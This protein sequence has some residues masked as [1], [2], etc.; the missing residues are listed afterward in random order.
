AAA[1][2]HAVVVL[3]ATGQAG[4][5]VRLT[6]ALKRR[7]EIVGIVDWRLAE[8]ER[9]GVVFRFNTY[10]DAAAVLAENPDLVVV[11]TGGLPNTAFL[12]AGED[13]VTTS[14][15]VLSGAVRP[16]ASVLLYDDNGG[17]AG[18]TAAEFVLG[19]GGALQIVTPE[20]ILAPDVGG[21]NYP[22]Y[23]KSLAQ[24]GVVTTL[25]LRLTAVRR[26][27]NA[28]QAVFFDEYG[29]TEVIKTA[30]QIVVEHG[31]MPLDDLY[32]ALKPDSANLGEVDYGALLA[33]RPQDLVRNPRGRF[34][35]FRIGD[36]VAS[37][38]IHAAIFDAIRLLKDI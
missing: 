12:D 8:C 34:R 25:N 27:G 37:R 13:L 17:H 30:D 22:A 23:F 2:G 5:Q 29:K 4:G 28:L 18:L 35:L 36:A 24:H 20:R 6:A 32:F 10:A 14:W 33:G 26:D 7:R 21:T 31:T 38:N 16:A 11:A 19:G 15:D 9:H 1:R 3:E